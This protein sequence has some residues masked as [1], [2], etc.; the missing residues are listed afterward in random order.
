MSERILSPAAFRATA[1][2]L[3]TIAAS[4]QVLTPDD[5]RN[6]A[7][8]LGDAAASLEAVAE[9]V[10]AVQALV[11][12]RSTAGTWERV[13]RAIAALPPEIQELAKVD[14]G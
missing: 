6:I 12:T 8:D 5:L 3:H 7:N 13:R 10:G 4:D 1:D 11:G 2:Q 14:H 9:L